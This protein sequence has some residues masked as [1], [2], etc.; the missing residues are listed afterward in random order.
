MQAEEL[1]A[2]V[3]VVVVFSG[4]FIVFLGLRQRSHQLEM[5]HKERL[6]MIERGLLPTEV[7]RRLSGGSPVPLRTV[8]AAPRRSLTFG[9]VLIALGFGLMTMIGIAAE[10]PQVAIGLGGAI[11]IIGIA[12]VV[13]NYATRPSEMAAHEPRFPDDP[14]V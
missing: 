2:L 12:F 14:S 6:A 11:V 9:I 7:E 13:I 5:R 8:A 10:A 1:F 4:V 3:F